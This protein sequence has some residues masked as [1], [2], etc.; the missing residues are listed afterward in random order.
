MKVE[1]KN[2]KFEPVTITLETQAE[3]DLLRSVVGR[4][5]GGIGG[6]F[7]YKLYRSLGDYVE[8]ADLYVVRDSSLYPT[9][10]AKRL[11]G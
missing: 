6:D 11:Y 3:V 5:S 4:T 9:E 8:H 10:E 1:S 7:M 2:A